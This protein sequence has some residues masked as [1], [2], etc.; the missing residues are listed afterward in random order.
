MIVDNETTDV[1]SLNY[2]KELQL[3]GVQVVKVPGAF[4]YARINNLAVAKANGDLVLLLN[5]DTEV[6]ER[7]W[8]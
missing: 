6:F 5:N 2:L 8:L 4:N 1:E 3:K 7:G